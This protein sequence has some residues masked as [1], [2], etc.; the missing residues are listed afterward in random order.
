MMYGRM[1]PVHLGHGLLFDVCL[2]T[3]NQIPNSEIRIYMSTTVD[4]ISNPIPHCFKMN[5]V[6]DYF[7][8]IFPYMQ[9]AQEGTLFGTLEKID[10]EFDNLV[11]VCGEDR[12]EH[13]NNV[14][15]K[16]NGT[17]YEFD[18]LSV[19]TYGGPRE[20]NKYS[21]TNLRQAIRDNN[22]KEFCTFLPNRGEAMNEKYYEIISH[23]MGVNNY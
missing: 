4:S 1:N 9:Q 2:S 3:M 13:F 8:S 7:P 21:A 17:L 15:H 11:L 18:E 22:Y 19:R 5:M 10:T 23:F 14:L 16:Y 20:Y 6:Q 12:Y